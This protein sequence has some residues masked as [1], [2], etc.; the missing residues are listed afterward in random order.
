MMMM[1]IAR[2]TFFQAIC[3]TLIILE[4][5]M[6]C[7]LALIFK[8]TLLAPEYAHPEPV[9]VRAHSVVRSAHPLE[10]NAFR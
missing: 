1:M 6:C 9:R 5:D 8:I 7:Y 3:C 2:K 4:C 10:L